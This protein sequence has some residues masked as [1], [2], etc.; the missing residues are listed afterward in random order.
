[1][2]LRLLPLGR[3]TRRRNPL[4]MYNVDYT[5]T[6]IATE[7]GKTTS[8]IASVNNDGVITSYTYD[9]VG[10]ITSETTGNQTISYAYDA[11]N[12]LTGVTGGDK[13]YAYTYDGNGNLLTAQKGSVTNTYTYGDTT[14]KDLLTAYNGQTITYDEI[15]NPLTYRDGITFTW[16]NGRKLATKEDRGR[17]CVSETGD[18][19]MS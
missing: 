15:G 2:V 1:M 14:W 7:A 16:K 4:A 11:L 10:N 3:L 9:T 18:G 8:Q 6:D 12:Q 5:Y 19:S 13:V 17:F